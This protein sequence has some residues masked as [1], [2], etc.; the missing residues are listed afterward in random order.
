[1][2]S[3]SNPSVYADDLGVTGYQGSLLCIE[4]MLAIMD[5]LWVRFYVLL[6]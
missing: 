3:P 4:N 6:L 2:P 1:M 5:M